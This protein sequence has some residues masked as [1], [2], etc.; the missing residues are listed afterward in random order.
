MEVSKQIFD[1]VIGMGTFHIAFNFLAIIGKKFLNSGLGDLLIESAV[2][3]ARTTLALMK[4][5]SY[6]KGVRAHKL[7]I[8][9]FFRLM[10]PEFVRWYNTSSCEQSRHLNEEELRGRIASGVSGVVKHENIPQIFPKLEEDL[11]GLI[12]CT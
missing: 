10:W 2:Y 4:G 1:V 7:C 5:K 8:E 12:L 9:A 3:A 6:N 11:D